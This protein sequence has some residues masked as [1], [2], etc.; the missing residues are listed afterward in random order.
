MPYKLISADGHVES[1]PSLW[2]HRVSAKYRDRAPQQGLDK[3]GQEAWVIGEH[4]MPIGINTTAGGLPYDQ[5]VEKNAGNYKK[6]D[7]SY[8]PGLGDGVQRVRELA[9]DGVDAEVLFPPVFGPNFIKH[10]L[11][12]GDKEAYIAVVQGYNT[13]L[14]LDYCAVAPDRLIGTCIIPETGID[15]AIA[16]MERCA[17]IGL[18]A[19]CL[20]N[21]PNGGE[22]ASPE[23]DRFWAASLDLNMKMAPHQNFGRGQKSPQDAPI[24]AFDMGSRSRVIGRPTKTM[25]QLIAT[26]VFDRFPKLQFYFA[27]ADCGWISFH[28]ES[29]DDWFLRYYH[30]RGIRLPKLPSQYWRDHARF[31]FASYDPSA[32]QQRYLIGLDLIMWGSDLPHSTGSWPHSREVLDVLFREVPADERKQI[33]VDNVCKYFD[34]DPDKELTPVP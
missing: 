1:H 6:P 33:L 13:W 18:P 29:S 15:D 16:E 14:G 25:G 12:N 4:S 11:D 30:H 32:I 3:K 21:F 20:N 7:G 2:S 5:M 28:L 24:K 10:I 34:L 9:V 23:D 26:G 17:R 8:R 22:D 31:C 19:V 27:E